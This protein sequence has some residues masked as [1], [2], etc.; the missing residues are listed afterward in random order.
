MGAGTL[1]TTHSHSASS[2][3]DRLASRV[4]QGRVLSID[5]AM[6]QIAHHIDF[7]VHVTLRD[8][9]WR[10]GVRSRFVSEVRQLTGAIESGRPSTHLVYRKA[11]E[12]SSEV[13][14]PE[15]AMSAELAPFMRA[16]SWG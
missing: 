1:S 11:T 3:I 2:T 8:E 13:F 7:I 16:G 6:R 9:A 15:A 12:T 14:A 5:D 4:A 10:G